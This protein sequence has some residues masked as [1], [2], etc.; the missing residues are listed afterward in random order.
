[1]N[2]RRHAAIAM[3]LATGMCVLPAYAQEEQEER[4]NAVEQ[5]TADATEQVGD[6]WITTKVKADL[7]A[8]KDVSGTAID[9]DTKNGV[10]TL[11]GTLAT[12]AEVDKAI[13]VAKGIRGVT[14]VKSK[15]KVGPPAK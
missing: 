7:L 12:R 13:S 8:T 5:T 3:A 1:M 6:A 10:V 14:S 11:S 15:L 9:V 2:T 4:G